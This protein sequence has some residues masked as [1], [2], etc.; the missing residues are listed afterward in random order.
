M[1]KINL[2]QVVFTLKWKSVEAVVLDGTA[3]INM[4]RPQASALDRARTVILAFPLFLS[5]RI[6]VFPIQITPKA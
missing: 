1:E 3:T 5:S 6:I 4:L 2:F